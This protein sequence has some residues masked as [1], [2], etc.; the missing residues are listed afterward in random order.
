MSKPKSKA[1]AKRKAKRKRAPKEPRPT[2]TKQAEQLRSLLAPYRAQERRRQ[3]AVVVGD[4]DAI[5]LLQSWTMVE[6]CWK[7]HAR[8]VPKYGRW[9]WLWRN[10]WYERD[11]L[12]DLAGVT[13]KRGR[14]LLDRLI[15]AQLVYPDG[16]ITADAAE[17]VEDHVD[18]RFPSRQRGRPKGS[19]DSKPRA[20]GQSDVSG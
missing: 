1:P 11:R 7:P 12:H 6:V 13:A 16:T 2:T 20:K 10:V 4:E 8:S 9:S 5:R 15:T 19:K 18:H 14:E 3:L 17:L